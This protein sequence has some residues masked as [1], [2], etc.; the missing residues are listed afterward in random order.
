MRIGHANIDV[1]ALD[2]TAIAVEDIERG[3]ALYRDLLGGDIVR[4]KEHADRGFGV[5]LVRYPN[6]AMI[7]LIE[8]I[9]PGFVRTFLDKRGEGVHH[10]TFLVRD[11]HAAVQAAIGAG[12]RVVDERYDHP[13]WQEAFISPRSAFGTLVQ[14]AQTDGASIDEIRHTPE[15]LAE[16]AHR[17]RSRR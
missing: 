1:L 8:P 10:I 5:A 7:E 2:H 17:R 9:G 13:G 6:G 4:H 11:I 16:V 14:L 3:L 12:L 15:Q